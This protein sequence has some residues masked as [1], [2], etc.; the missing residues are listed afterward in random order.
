MAD[1]RPM[2][3]NNRAVATTPG[4]DIIA[5][6]LGDNFT[7]KGHHLLM[8]KD[9][10]FDSRARADPHKYIAEFVEICIIFLYGNT[11]V[12]S[13]KLKL[14]P[15]SLSRD[16]KVWFNELSPGI[17]TTWEEMR[18]DLIF[19]HGLDEATQAI[20]DARGIFLYK[21]PNEAHQLLEDRVLLKLDWSKDIKAKPLWKTVA[22]AEDVEDHTP[23]RSVITNTWE[24]PK[25]KKQT[26]PTEDIE[27]V[28]EEEDIEETAKHVNVVFTR[29]GKTYDPPVNLNAK[30]TI[31]DD[32]NE[33]EAD[34]NE[35]EEES[36]SSQ[37]T[38]TDPPPLKA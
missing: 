21:T 19:Y 31:I 5:V 27:K 12:D 7:V 13:I 6:D 1:D 28:N 23:H 18:Q 24:D 17:I 35:K 37:Q 10:Q 36:S 26:M 20:L 3:G 33:D 30:N 4:S 25:K 29:S 11:N 2:W 15:S 32:D 8:I 38:E 34:K 16:T 14:F 9:R 22:F